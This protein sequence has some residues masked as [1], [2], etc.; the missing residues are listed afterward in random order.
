MAENAGREGEEFQVDLANLYRE[1]TFTDLRAA[2]VRRM[3]PVTPDGQ[4]DP[5]RDVLY[6][7]ETTLMTQMGPVPVSF[8]LESDSLDGAFQRFPEGVQ[9]AIERLNER[10]RE[11]VRD[12][13]SRIVVPGSGGGVPPDL[14]GGGGRGG[15]IPG[16]GKFGLK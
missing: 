3:T 15:G 2:T 7:G 4:T 6:V 1:E 8:A 9:E 13:A 12:E 5:H 16:G 14:G 11:M 10:A